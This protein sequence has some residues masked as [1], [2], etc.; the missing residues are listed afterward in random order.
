VLR[1]RVIIRRKISPVKML[2]ILKAK[3]T[4]PVRLTEICF[5]MSD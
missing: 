1:V 4:N 3:T 2:T 5:A